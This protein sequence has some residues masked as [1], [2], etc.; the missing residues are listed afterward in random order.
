MNWNSNGPHN[1]FQQRNGTAVPSVTVSMIEAAYEKK[2]L[3]PN[4][5]EEI[6]NN[7]AGAYSAG[8]D[9]VGNAA[10]VAF[11]I[12]WLIVTVGCLSVIYLPTC[13]ALESG[14]ATES[15]SRA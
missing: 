1:S 3:P 4:Y 13:H 11:S 15:A 14:C 9:T 7:A 6:R 12:F 8:S 5:D 10:L 2:D